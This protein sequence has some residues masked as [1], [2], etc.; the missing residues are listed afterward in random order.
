[1]QRT[2]HCHNALNYLCFVFLA[3]ARIRRPVKFIDVFQPSL[4]HRIEGR[5]PVVAWLRLASPWHRISPPARRKNVLRMRLLQVA[6][7]SPATCA[8]QVA[9]LPANT[10]AYPHVGGARRSRATGSRACAVRMWRGDPYPC[11]SW[12]DPHAPM[13]AFANAWED[14]TR[15]VGTVLRQ[16][17]H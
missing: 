3:D 10:A 7:C 17:N 11:Q 9:S 2:C 1:M 14:L 15:T 16:R 8:S 4:G 13:R 12:L 5:L 6:A